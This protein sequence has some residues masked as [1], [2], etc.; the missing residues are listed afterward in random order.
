MVI[1]YTIS[2]YP[3]LAEGL[4]AKVYEVYATGIPEAEVGSIAIPAPHN[5]PV[6]IVFPGLDTMV[7][8]V[9]LIGVTS[10]IEFHSYYEQPRRDTV[11]IF[12]AIRFKIGDG[13]GLTPAAGASDYTNPALIGVSINDLLV[14][15]NGYGY[16]LPG[17]QYGFDST[18]GKISLPVP[19]TF[20][21]DGG[22]DEYLIT[23]KP[24]VI[25]ELVNDSVVGK[26]Y[27]GFVD[28]AAPTNYIAAHLRKLIRLAGV[29][30]IYT[31]PVGASIP[32]GY[33]HCFTNFGAYALVTDKPKVRFL[34]A[35]LKWGNG[36]VTE[37]EVPFSATYSFTFDG[38]QWNCTMFTENSTLPA[39]APF[40]KIVYANSQH[41][42]DINVDSF[43]TI[44]IPEQPNTNYWPLGNLRGIG[45]DPNYDNDI[46]FI[47]YDK[48]VDSF[49]IAVREVT[50]VI[51]NLMFDFI[52]VSI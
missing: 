27:G 32:V 19:E 36:T 45:N 46:F 39:T 51:Q 18:T 2:E 10:G 43:F 33:Q 20:S 15:K 42:G 11:T 4:V 17:T 44:D 6:E 41:I 9:K 25:S 3:A 13:G 30:A 38:A 5:A 7:H 50:Y 40:A 1:K 48:R 29:N 22:G 16:L 35:P 24:S 52:I 28:I 26:L 8:R 49:K 31:F 37:V 47:T 23:R 14:H 21:G 34:N 12:D